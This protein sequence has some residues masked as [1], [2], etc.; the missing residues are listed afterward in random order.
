M[1]FRRLDISEYVASP[2]QSARRFR[3]LAPHERVQPLPY[4][5]EHNPIPASQ[6]GE[7][8]GPALAP[9]V[10]QK[11][12]IQAAS[13]LP[14]AVESGI[15]SGSLGSQFRGG[16]PATAMF[17]DL[18]GY[19]PNMLERAIGTVAG[20]ASSPELVATAAGGPVPIIAGFALNRALTQQRGRV[21]TRT[22]AAHD[23]IVGA[24]TGGALLVG[25]AAGM[26]VGGKVLGAVWPR[27]FNAGATA[28][29]RV[30][31]GG[32]GA[33]GAMGTT[34]AV[35]QGRMPTVDDYVEAL[36]TVVAF[37]GVGIAA[38]QVKAAATK[39]FAKKTA[40]EDL[41]PEEQYL[42]DAVN[43]SLNPPE[44]AAGGGAQ[45]FN[46][47]LE[48]P[49]SR[50][51][52]DNAPPIAATSEPPATPSP[53]SQALADRVRARLA[54]REPIPAPVEVP[55]ETQPSQET[56]NAEAIRGNQG[57]AN[58]VGEVPAGGKGRGRS[59]LQQAA[60]RPPN[61]PGQA[62]AQGEVAPP[63]V[64]PRAE[65]AKE[66]AASVSRAKPST[67][68]LLAKNDIT[69]EQ[70]AQIEKLAPSSYGDRWLTDNPNVQGLAKVAPNLTVGVKDANGNHARMTLTHYAELSKQ[71][72]FTD[73][74]RRA[75]LWLEKSNEPESMDADF[76]GGI[77]KLGGKEITGEV[78]DAAVFMGIKGVD[79]KSESS[80][81]KAGAARIVN[82]LNDANVQGGLQKYGIKSVAIVPPG[83]LSLS[84][85][86]NIHLASKTIQLNA[87]ARD[88]RNAIL[89]EIGHVEYE[90]LSASERALFKKLV[91]E[92]NPEELAGYRSLAKRDPA[93]Y[94]KEVFAETFGNIGEKWA[95]DILR[96]VMPKRLS[97][98]AKQEGKVKAAASIAARIV[99]NTVK[100]E[101]G[102][103]SWENDTEL[104]DDMKA[105]AHAV[106]AEGKVKF[107]E[108]NAR[109][110]ELL[111]ES[112]DA[113]AEHMNALHA[114]LQ[115]PEQ[116]DAGGGFKTTKAAIAGRREA[117]GDEPIEPS[118]PVSAKEAAQ[119]AGDK[120]LIHRVPAILDEALAESRGL[121]K[122]EESAATAYIKQKAEEFQAVFDKEGLTPKAE[123]LKS[124]LAELEEKKTRVGAETGRS[125]Q[126]ISR[127]VSYDLAS[128]VIRAEKGAG[129]KATPQEVDAFNS[130]VKVL[131]KSERD[132]K[133][134]VQ[135]QGDQ[136]AEIE[137][138]IA[139]ARVKGEAA[140]QSRKVK[141]LGDRERIKRELVDLN[142]SFAK[143]LARLNT[144]LSPEDYIELAKIIGK[145]IELGAI[146]FAE[147][148][149]RVRSDHK[150]IT[151]YDIAK[152][153]TLKTKRV[154]DATQRELI[155]RRNAIRRE[156]AILQQLR[157][158]NRASA[159]L[160]A[161]SK[162]L[163]ALRKE[164]RGG[165]YTPEKAKSLLKAIADTNEAIGRVV[166]GRKAKVRDAEALAKVNDG[167]ETILKKA[168]SAK[169]LAD[170]Q[171]QIRTGDYKIAV[172]P[173]PRPTPEVMGNARK[174]DAARHS[175]YLLTE[176]MRKRSWPEIATEIWNTTRSVKTAGDFGGLLYNAPAFARSHPLKAAKIF[177][178]AFHAYFSNHTAAQTMAE[179]RTRSG[180]ARAE[181]AG[182]DLTLFGTEEFNR[183]EEMF[184]SHTAENLPLL[185]AAVRAGERNYV[186]SMNLARAV[187]FDSIADKFPNAG[188]ADLKALAHMVNAFTGRGEWGK[189]MSKIASNTFFA[190]RRTLSKVEAPLTLI[191]YREFKGVRNEVAKDVGV[192]LA[193]TMAMLGLG[194]VVAGGLIWNNPD[195]PD[196]LKTRKGG[197][198]VD[199]FTGGLS[200]MRL[201]LRLFFKAQVW[202]Q[203]HKDQTGIDWHGI[204]EQDDAM[205]YHRLDYGH[206][207]A[208]EEIGQFLENKLHP[209]PVML[210]EWW[211]G[212][213]LYGGQ[214]KPSPLV[215]APLA[216]IGIDNLKIQKL[217]QSTLDATT[218]L[219]L[220]DAY[221]AAVAEGMFVGTAAG[222]VSGIGA[223]N[224][225][226]YPPKAVPSQ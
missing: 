213:K 98:A 27:A 23:L 181:K 56:Q 99:K 54:K 174:V 110:K 8:V 64:P 103:L 43:A 149:D 111:A 146:D 221:D 6:M 156:S 81:S 157:E 168:D 119:G 11:P 53:E 151:E 35:E 37:H 165:Q 217:A 83:S 175:I 61:A 223:A 55:A 116:K 195:D 100:G 205:A 129:R 209:T 158:V 96:E 216:A 65:T 169:D 58:P 145:H 42:D 176:S 72:G 203:S 86:A 185:G 225:Q 130:N 25:E 163:K 212:N 126:A 4:D 121:N 19:D 186:T 137:R 94:D 39:I 18:E 79:V 120:G 66:G 108:W 13:Y 202:K 211:T 197:I 90:H 41:T 105:L 138:K 82:A 24:A 36:A 88:P 20:F 76:M 47:P 201:M 160:L 57:F 22:E 147:L 122:E 46:P 75:N 102:S 220:Q 71:K 167:L 143:R 152:A 62:S 77:F 210:Y 184:R 162:R 33:V 182:L 15:A 2:A 73:R 189:E 190:P 113:L 140:R 50:A 28:A 142:Q 80:V 95:N 60:P 178:R 172:I 112:Y 177:G 78:A 154:L 10:I 3:R 199:W 107:D 70:F 114:A 93:Q 136:L 141:R 109:M 16:R 148:V 159:N 208:K 170:Y 207:S 132:L 215:T 48:A 153:L 131:Q 68:E 85:E 191:K 97:P 155:R 118:A 12:L 115:P 139:E 1:A 171:T 74:V 34:T 7:Q 31:G 128:V 200:I 9:G 183:K 125:L 49:I 150:S 117:R 63:I 124:E 32:A 192:S 144:G 45:T 67:A 52:S 44:Q 92:A 214:V 222:V 26:A 59:D 133:D 180:F 87:D 91:T 40:G 194:S 134:S 196:W 89:H 204:V 104:R 206:L 17:P 51:A 173:P 14:K 29:G 179:L 135:K 21:P 226:V 101:S 198:V 193:A 187:W 30:V 127:E 218:M 38:N 84:E 224:I 5:I 166:E 188:D 161:I 219:F 123:K 164:V 106:Y 69:E